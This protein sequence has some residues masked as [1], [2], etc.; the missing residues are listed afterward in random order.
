MSKKL[1]ASIIVTYRCN[2]RCNMCDVWKFPSKP[3][4]EIGVDV[5]EKLPEMF[6]TN[7]TG[8]EPFVRQDLPEIIAALRKKTK[9]IVISTNGFFTERI[10]SLCK[11]YP[12][13]GIRISIE[14]QQEANDAIRQIPDGYNRT[15]KT[16]MTLRDM[17]VK[18]IGFGTTV[19]D[20]N[21]KDLIK[22]YE[23]ADDLGYEFATATL[24]NS[25]YFCKTDNKIQNK[26]EVIAEFEKLIALLIK[27]RNVKKWFRAYFNYGLINYINGKPRLLPCEMGQD[28]FFVDPYGDVVPCNG[29]DVKMPMGN[30]NTQS[31]DEIWNSAQARAVREAVRG[32]GKN[33]WMIGSVAPAMR[34]HPVRPILW[35]LK[36][37]LWM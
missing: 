33:C 24:H 34:H 23:M 13:L 9:R 30:L 12:D 25:H 18:D 5:I 35:V 20:I 11:K 6:F 16:L 14:G 10:I 37:K 7:I 8:G 19:Q 32:C 26:K 21:C 2:A 28:G 1:H 31:W 15:I 4:E 17:G 27:S 3:A 29:M 36:K 22:L